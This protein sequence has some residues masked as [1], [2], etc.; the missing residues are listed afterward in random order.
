ML[1]FLSVFSTHAI[2]KDLEAI[3]LLIYKS[4][5]KAWVIE[6]KGPADSSVQYTHKILFS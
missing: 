6:N 4:R 1:G 5:I 3:T 2:S